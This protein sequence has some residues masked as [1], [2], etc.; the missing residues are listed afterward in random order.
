MLSMFHL[1]HLLT[2]IERGDC[3]ECVGAALQELNDVVESSV[4]GRED[5][6]SNEVDLV[7]VSY[8]LSRINSN[9]ENGTTVSGDISKVGIRLLYVH[10]Y[11]YMHTNASTLAS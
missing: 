1:L 7:A 6:S 5:S 9:L 2:Q 10:T 4:A 3:P 8:L 11:M